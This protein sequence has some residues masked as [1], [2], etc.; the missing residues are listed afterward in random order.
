MGG[1]KKLIDL[2]G[3]SSG[4]IITLLKL[5]LVQNLILGDIAG[6]EGFTRGKWKKQTGV[7]SRLD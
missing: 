2:A 5:N 6:W 1:S 7:M 3:L 4:D